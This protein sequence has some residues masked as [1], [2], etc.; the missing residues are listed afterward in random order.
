MESAVDESWQLLLSLFPSGWEQQAVLSGAVERLRGFA[1]VGE[2]LRVLLLHVGKGYSLRET[3]VRAKQSGLAKVSDVTLLNRLREAE[4]WWRWLCM[5]L[6]AESGWH[7][8]ADSRGYNV[9]A[10][11]GTLIKEP[12]RTGALWRIHYSLR[13]PSL[14][15]DHLELTAIRGSGTGEKLGRFA[16]A[17]GD[18]ILADRGFC[19]PGGVSLLHQQGAA[20]IVRLN[21]TSLPLYQANGSKFPLLDHVRQ[22][23]QAGPVL[24]WKVWVHTAEGRIAGRLCGMRKSEQSARRAQRRIVLKSQQG[25]P[26]PKPETLEYANYIMV[27]TTLSEEM[28]PAADVMEWYRVR[29]QIELVF[30]RLKSLAQLGHLPKRDDRSSRSW[31][32]GKLLVALLSQKLQ[33]LG[34]DI[35]PWGYVAAEVQAQMHVARI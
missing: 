25:G 7:M 24:Q 11:D 13:I 1:S 23:P 31:L 21:T 2:L 12:G 17:P 15:C 16:A 30:K 29:W 33:R 32:Y 6:L 27:F 14:E 3:A 9:R 34:S 35:S 5:A 26:S 4:P 10:L 19:K 28:F 8:S 20:V 22:L 18:L